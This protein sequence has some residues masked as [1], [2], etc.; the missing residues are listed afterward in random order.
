MNAPELSLVVPCHNEEKNL[1]PLVAAI[2]A[3]LDPLVLEYEIVVTDDCSMDDSWS[4]LKQLA[5]NDPRLRIQRFESNC[6]ESAASWA[7]MQAARGRYIATLDADLQNDPGDLPALLEG[8]KNADCIC[9]TRITTRGE[10]DNWIRIASSR[11]ANSVRNK[12]SGE[13]ITDAGCTYRVFKRECIEHV[14]FFKGAH[15]FLPTLI[16]ME[17]FRVAEVPVSTKPRFS[18]TSHYGVWNRLFKSFRDLLGVRWLKS[19]QI[20][21]EIAE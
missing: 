15:R 14:R 8:L 4:V 17:G 2:H 7:G 18:G 20:R 3:V 10:G 9:G 13:N 21:Y 19:R 12:L 16:K 11:I 1:Q 5:A 6:G